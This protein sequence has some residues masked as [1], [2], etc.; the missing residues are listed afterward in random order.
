MAVGLTLPSCFLMWLPNIPAVQ[1]LVIGPQ[2]FTEGVVMP[3]AVAFQFGLHKPVDNTSE[4]V[5]S[6][7]WDDAG[8]QLLER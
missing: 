4:N 1:G 2:L 8:P 5:S 6:S 7:S 3:P